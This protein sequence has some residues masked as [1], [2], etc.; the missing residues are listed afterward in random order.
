MGIFWQRADGT[1]TAVRLTE[2]ETDVRHV[3]QSFSPDGSVLLFDAV[4]GTGTTTLLALSLSEA[5][6]E[7]FGDVETTIRRL[8]TGAVFSP[9]G[10]WVAYTVQ[11]SAFQGA[12]VYVQPYPANGVRVLVSGLTKMV[13]IRSGRP[14]APSF[15]TRPV[16]ATSWLG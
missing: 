10:D 7:P 15:S 13:T 2:P 9:D 1:D 4:T 11:E 14:T 12:R 6:V 3:P 5:E 16:Q 8:S